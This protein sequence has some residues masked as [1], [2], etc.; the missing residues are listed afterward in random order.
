MVNHG[1]IL[2]FIYNLKIKLALDFNEILPVHDNIVVTT[3]TD[4]EGQ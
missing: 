2:S 3:E 1:T 4:L